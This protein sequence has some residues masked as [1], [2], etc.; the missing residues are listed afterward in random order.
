MSGVAVWI[1]GIVGAV[2]ATALIDLMM[3]EGETKKF[4]KGIASL[5]VLAVIISPLPALI[6]KDFK[7]DD[8]VDTYEQTTLTNDTYLQRVYLHRYKAYELAIQ[9]KLKAK[10]LDEVI[11]RI[12]IEYEGGLITVQSIEVDTSHMVFTGTDRNIDS[13]AIITDAVTSV[14]GQ[15]AVNKIVIE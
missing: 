7:L 4:I 10:G 3:A 12:A 15:G 14:L 1:S 6:N 9:N 11:V 2:L 5:L 13:N 8:S